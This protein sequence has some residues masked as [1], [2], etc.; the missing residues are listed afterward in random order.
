MNEH[1]EGCSGRNGWN[2]GRESCSGGEQ[3]AE[4]WLDLGFAVEVVGFSGMLLWWL[5]LASCCC[6]RHDGHCQALPS[7]S[8]LKVM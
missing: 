1:G 7:G 3:D 6:G 5:G 8:F 4:K 2:G